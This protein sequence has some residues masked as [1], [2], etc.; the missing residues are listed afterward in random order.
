[1][2]NDTV[3]ASRIVSKAAVTNELNHEHSTPNT[4]TGSPSGERSPAPLEIT[5]L[6]FPFEVDGSD[7]EA[8]VERFD[9]SPARIACAYH[10]G[11]DTARARELLQ[12]DHL[13]PHDYSI[14]LDTLRRSIVASRS[15][16]TAANH[17]DVGQRA[18]GARPDNYVHGGADGD[19]LTETYNKLLTCGVFNR[20]FDRENNHNVNLRWNMLYSL[21]EEI[22]SR[23]QRDDVIAIL[24][25]VA[26][27]R[28]AHR[29]VE[30]ALESVGGDSVIAVSAVRD[31][32]SERNVSRSLAETSSK[33]I[34]QQEILRCFDWRAI[35]KAC[36]IPVIAD[37]DGSLPPVGGKGLTMLAGVAMAA[38][39]RRLANKYVFFSDT[40]FLRPWEYDSFAHL[41]IP[42][43]LGDKFIPRLIKTAKTGPGRNNEAWTRESNSLATDPR[44][45][46]LTRGTALLCQQFIWPLSGNLAMRGDDL[47]NLPFAT[48]TGIETQINAFYAGRQL[49][50]GECE[51]AQVCNPNPLLEDGESRPVRESAM[52][53]RC[54]MWLR[55]VLTSVGEFEKPLH[56][57]SLSDIRYFNTSRGGAQHWGA[58]QDAFHGPLTPSKIT[59]DYMLPSLEQCDRIG[60]INWE[61]MLR[62]YRP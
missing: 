53:G 43:A 14:A 4:P 47:Y 20:P 61:R 49:Q 62:T 56:D 5:Q 13:P 25:F 52:I 50:R 34:S 40:D 51:V 7:Y 37:S 17:N 42:L 59:L 60:A 2:E 31:L 38:A 36:E 30:Y 21:R 23:L 3:R 33:L 48:G 8:G 12:A 24:P 39:E 58:F 41:G 6:R 1:M 11:G 45:H 32:E 55:A 19:P 28:T 29:N 54:Q 9:D 26:E 44:Q 35:G 15:E 46:E 10:V 16:S 18:R 22:I 27:K 57:W